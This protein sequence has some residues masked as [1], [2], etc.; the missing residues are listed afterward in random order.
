MQLNRRLMVTE[1]GVN[2]NNLQPNIVRCPPDRLVIL[3]ILTYNKDYGR[4][5]IQGN[6]DGSEIL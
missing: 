1:N 5:Q 3:H 4:Y 2:G 6:I